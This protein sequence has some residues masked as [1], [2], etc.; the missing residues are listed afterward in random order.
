MIKENLPIISRYAILGV[1]L[2]FVIQIVVSVVFATIGSSIGEF[3]QN[4]A[5]I[6]LENQ[7][8]RQEIVKMES[9]LNIQAR[10]GELGFKEVP[11]IY[12]PA[13]NYNGQAN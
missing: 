7:K 6:E 8:I 13:P 2:L 9:I 1:L 3:E 4:S 12:L 10:A 11:I 5:A